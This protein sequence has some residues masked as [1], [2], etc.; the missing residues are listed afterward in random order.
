M[1]FGNGCLKLW[2]IR[3][4]AIQMDFWT[5]LLSLHKQDIYALTDEKIGHGRIK[6]SV[7][8]LKFECSYAQT[9]ALLLSLM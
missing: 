9:I 3:M 8:S 7:L 5:W 1:Y 2:L 6:N 4:R